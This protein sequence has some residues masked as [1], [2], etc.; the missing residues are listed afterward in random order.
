MKNRIA[1]LGQPNSGKST[2]FNALTGSRQHVGNWPGKT[3][4]KID[5]YYTFEGTRF[6]VTDLPGRFPAEKTQHPINPLPIISRPVQSSRI[7]ICWEVFWGKAV[8]ESPISV[9]TGFFKTGSRS[10][11]IFRSNSAPGIRSAVIL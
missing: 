10:K 5:G 9:M 1:L 6:T 7:D 8:M 3:V 11:N 4:E 2:V